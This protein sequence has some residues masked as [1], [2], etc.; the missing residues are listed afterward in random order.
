VGEDLGT[1]GAGVREKLAANGVLGTRVVYFEEE[2]PAAWPRDV[3]ATATTHD[4]PTVAG[5]WTGADADARAAAGLPAED[6]S[7]SRA[8]VRR[9][10]GEDATA[11]EAVV[12]THR[13]LAAS[14]AR[15]VLGTID[16]VLVVEERP[17]MPGTT[18][19]WDNWS[20][21]LPVPVDELVDGPVPETL[22]ALTDRTPAD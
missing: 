10:A 19:E 18:D 13:A 21:A 15:V 1:V 8:R 2:P 22:R 12:A 9:L 14:P 20:I 7:E 11:E 3:L 17:N 6:H 5:V 4:L 16:D